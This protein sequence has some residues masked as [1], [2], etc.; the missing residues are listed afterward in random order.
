MNS[1]NGGERGR[2]P[3][4]I[5]I[6]L[7][8]HGADPTIKD[9]KG[10]SPLSFVAGFQVPGQRYTKD[11]SS[12]WLHQLM[13]TYIDDPLKLDDTMRWQGKGCYGYTVQRTDRKLSIIT[14]TVYN[15]PDRLWEL[16]R[17]NNIRYDNPYRVGDCLKVFD[18]VWCVKPLPA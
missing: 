7:L 14:Q 8:D 3:V 10:N 1:R 5:T 18:V 15:D 4:S 17:L 11:H 2:A 16:A 12:G 9:A 6:L 13:L